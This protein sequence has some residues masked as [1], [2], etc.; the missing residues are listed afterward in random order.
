MRTERKVTDKIIDGAE[1]SQLD[2]TR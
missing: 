2:V 1:V